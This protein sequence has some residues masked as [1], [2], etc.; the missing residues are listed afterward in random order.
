MN[1]TPDQKDRIRQGLSK[2]KWMIESEPYWAPEIMRERKD[3]VLTD[4]LDGLK[5]LSEF[6]D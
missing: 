4:V 2:A 1:I 5:A 6:D 3:E